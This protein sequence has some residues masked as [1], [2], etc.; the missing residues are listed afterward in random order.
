MVSQ[1]LV[2][3]YFCSSVARQGPVEQLWGGAGAGRGSWAQEHP[4]PQP[5]C[6]GRPCGLCQRGTGR[7]FWRYTGLVA[8]HPRWRCAR[9]SLL[10]AG[11]SSPSSQVAVS[12]PNIGGKAARLGGK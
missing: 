7:G 8:Q 12:C 3:V 6:P 9:R 10:V 5:C 1:S 4:F 11:G 2:H